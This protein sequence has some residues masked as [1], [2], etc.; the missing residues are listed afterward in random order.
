MAAEGIA[1]GAPDGRKRGR[2]GR[3]EMR[4]IEDTT[5]RQVTFS[6]RRSGL[7]KKAFELS[8]LCDAEVAL[9][10]FSTRGRLYQFASATDLRKTIDRYLIHTNEKA[11]EP[12]VERWKLEATTLG[13]KIDA[14]EAYKRKLLGENLGSCSTQELQELEVQL[15]KS[16]S[17]IRQ[18]K[19]KKLMDQIL[20]L[21]E[22]ERKLLKEKEM[23]RGQALPLLELNKGHMHA[24]ALLRTTTIGGGG[25]GGGEEESE[26]VE[27]ELAIGIGR[28]S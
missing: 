18:K 11:D 8:V 14:I 25:G 3:R 2:R 7:L 23:L 22:K 6:K 19:Q 21:R 9:I 24:A 1:A 15:E 5:S 28:R 27:T 4:R 10:V 20:E 26:E 17:S 13:K 12:G 16:L